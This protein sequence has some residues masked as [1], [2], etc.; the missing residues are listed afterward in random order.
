MVEVKSEW[1][2]EIIKKYI[3]YKFLFSGKFTL[4]AITAFVVCFAVI[5][6]FCI[7]MF[8]TMK[9]AAFLVIAIAVALFIA[10]ITAFYII[11]VNKTVKSTVKNAKALSEN[12]SIILTEDKITVCQNNIPYN[13]TRWDEITSID[14]NDMGKAA[15]LSAKNGAVVILEYKNIINGTEKE[16]MEMLLIKNDKLSE[17]A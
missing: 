4:A 14:I 11:K 3:M 17:K 9:S 13:E 15:Y 1:T 7:T 8:V 12:Q 10:G 2:E 16:L 6:I 5:M